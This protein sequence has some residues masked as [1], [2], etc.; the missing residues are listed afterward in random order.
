MSIRVACHCGHV[1]RARA[2]LA[3]KELVCPACARKCPVPRADTDPLPPA[4]PGEILCAH[5]RSPLLPDASVCRE[6][7]QDATLHVAPPYIVLPERELA[8]ICLAPTLVPLLAVA[9][10]LSEAGVSS[11]GYCV[12][13]FAAVPA[14]LVLS[15][16]R[17]RFDVLREPT[18]PR[19]RRQ[20]TVAWIPVKY[21]EIDLAPVRTARIAYD[22][23]YIKR[24]SWVLAAILGLCGIL[25]GLIYAYWLFA[26]GPQDE[27][28]AS[29]KFDAY[30]MHWISLIDVDGTILETL[31][32]RREKQAQAM[33]RML[34]SAVDIDVE[35]S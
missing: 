20:F 21:R 22:E 27:D 17:T 19:F 6:C 8:L 35:R 1:T 2:E 11:A 4:L 9:G 10:M 16:T 30:A 15:G 3:G 13:L 33:L 18:G 32:I 34:T 26:Q 14:S 25:P 12:A 23:C 28:G 31:E 5:C 29:A 24:R 7:G